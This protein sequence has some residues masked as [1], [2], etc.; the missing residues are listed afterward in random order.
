MQYAN[1][2]VQGIQHLINFIL[3]YDYVTI[4]VH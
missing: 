1:A 2:Y 4:L 3:N